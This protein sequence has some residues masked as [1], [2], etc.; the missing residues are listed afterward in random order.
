MAVS[1]QIASGHWAA[2]LIG[3]ALLLTLLA[4]TA[5]GLMRVHR[6]RRS[7]TTSPP[8]ERAP[9]PLPSTMGASLWRCQALIAEAVV[10]RQ[11]LSGQ[12]DA[13]TYRIRMNEL[14][15]QFNS[16]RRPQRNA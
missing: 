5:A 4:T 1:G 7:A 6:A 13:E 10:A 12:I 9:D 15:R 14:A 16:E 2:F 3:V 8:T 11:R